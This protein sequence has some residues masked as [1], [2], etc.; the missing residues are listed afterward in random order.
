[1]C[2]HW[3]Q[4]NVHFSNELANWRKFK[5]YQQDLQP[6]DRLETGLKLRNVD[7]SLINALTRLSDWQDFEAFQ[8]HN[9]AE[10]TNFEDHCRQ[11]FLE[12][13][14][15]KAST[16]QSSSSP[17]P[18]G[19]FGA[20]LRSFNRNQEAI[21]AA[22]KQLKWIKDQWP[23]VVTEAFASGS[24]T[25]KLQSSLE[26]NFE[27]QT[28]SA[29]SAIQKLGG[30]QATLSVHLMNL[31]MFSIESCTGVQKHSSIRTSYY[32]GKISSSGDE[33]S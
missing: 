26:A 33:V 24:I 14:D 12:I 5:K 2:H 10:A 9:L 13:T 30:V 18:H 15:W 1:M 28:L 27:K 23:K 29:F 17:P 3:K 6:S 4:E 20:W 32:I 19:A 25:P 7:A 8:Y 22:K 11:K 31:W 21:E 16:E